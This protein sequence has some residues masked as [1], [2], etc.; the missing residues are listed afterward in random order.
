MSGPD[1][2]DSFPARA[3]SCIGPG[4]FEAQKSCANHSHRLYNMLE[5]NKTFV[6][7]ERFKEFHREIPPQ[8]RCVIITCMDTRLT[9]LLPHA[10]NILD[11]D[12][13]IIK[14]AGA[15]ITHPFGGIMRSVMVALYELRADEVFVIG[16]RFVKI[17]S[18]YS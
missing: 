12:A 13:K 9:H 8:K 5:F 14:N 7:E 11:G 17:P 3:G 1:N 16:H 15:V 18:T 6:K 2:F 10:I 4:N